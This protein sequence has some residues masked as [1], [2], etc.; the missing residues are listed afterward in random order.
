DGEWIED[1]IAVKNE[2]LS[3]FQSRFDTPCADRLI[4]NMEF[5]NRLSV[6]Q[7]Q[8]LE[9]PFLKAAV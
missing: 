5:P 7:A 3:H 4:F 9:R 8:D 1:P 6:D 2:F